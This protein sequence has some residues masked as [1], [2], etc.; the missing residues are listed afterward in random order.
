[1]VVVV[2]VVVAAHVVFVVVLVIVVE[3][4]IWKLTY[5]LFVT[6]HSCYLLCVTASCSSRVT[7]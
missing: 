4:N 7:T 2:V 1:V 6:Q 3:N 5:Q